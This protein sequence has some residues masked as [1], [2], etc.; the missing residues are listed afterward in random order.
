[1]AG[2][3]QRIKRRGHSLEALGGHC[4][5]VTLGSIRFQLAPRVY[6]PPKLTS[7]VELLPMAVLTPIGK[8]HLQSQR[9]LM[10]MLDRLLCIRRMP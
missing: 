2:L 6:Q 4:P 5:R 8:R 7:V 1:M 9:N 10:L 3:P